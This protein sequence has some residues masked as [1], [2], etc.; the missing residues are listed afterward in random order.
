[1]P[2]SARKS[3]TVAP[4]RPSRARDRLSAKVPKRSQRE[5]LLDAMIELAT[6]VGYQQVSIAQVSSRAGV[7]S[8][9]FYDQFEDKED[10]LVSAYWTAASSIVGP[11]K[12]EDV[13]NWPGTA[14]QPLGEFLS[15]LRA[16]P[17][18]GRLLLVE[19]RAAGARMRGEHERALDMLERRIEGELDRT[20]G[21]RRALDLPASVLVGGVRSVAVWRLRGHAED[22][23]PL[24]ADDLMTWIGSYASPV[25]RGRWSVG[26]HAVRPVDPATLATPAPSMPERLPRGRHSL[27]AGVV[28]RTQR[29][30]VIYGTAEA[31]MEKGFANTTVADIVTAA[32]VSREVFYEHFTDKLHAFL[33]AQRYSTQEALDACAAEYFSV[34]E[35]PERVW[36]ALG[37]LINLII[38]HPS[39]SYLR[40]VEC[41]AAGPAAL[42]RAEDITKSFT[43]FLEEGFRYR[44]E[45]ASLPRVCSHAIA[46]SIFEVIYRHIARGE[47]GAL[48][49]QLPR[50]AYVA[51]AP[52]TGPEEAIRLVTDLSAR[53]QGSHRGNG[54]AAH[55]GPVRRDQG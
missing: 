30:R 42:S 40:V 29:T 8:A 2:S 54:D 12:V 17:A 27:P 52:F 20:E 43:V 34:T 41:Y 7:S 18:A 3:A 45:A 46:G 24:L 4:P 32:G 14:K 51:L 19:S 25:E 28:T 16:Q 1:M 11:L 35:W 37:T 9:T 21:R 13:G 50:L 55:A 15:A 49:G 38:S 39:L 33:E 53:D 48:A 5:R 22:E 10:C 26:P 44:P 47:V 6:Q 31:M 23:L 36:R